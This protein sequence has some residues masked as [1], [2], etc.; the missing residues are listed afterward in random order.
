MATEDQRDPAGA[1]MSEQ[2]AAPRAPRT[3]TFNILFV[4]T[5]NTC[6]SPLA[7]GIARAEI[8]RRGWKNV[9]VAS[10]G[11]AASDGGPASTEAVTVAG[12]AGIDL[13]GH[14]SRRLSPR[15]AAWADLI[16]AMGGSHVAALEH[17]GAGERAT[18]LG[19][20]AAGEE[21]EGHSVADPFG[22]SEAVYQETF[23]ELRE[24]I[25]AALD[26]LAPILDP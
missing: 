15:I 17:L 26:R 1:Q 14:R 6:R 19:D 7:E 10:A 25:T 13:A 5:G 22:G 24:L 9:E 18:T 21:G 11:L 4:C 20:F 2:N 3:T 16:L 12:R 8:E 23:D